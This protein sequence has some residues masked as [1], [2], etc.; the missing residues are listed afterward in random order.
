M[1]QRSVR[2]FRGG[3]IVLPF[4]LAFAG[5]CSSSSPDSSATA[6][7]GAERGACYPNGTCNTGLTCASN[8]CVVL[9]DAGT[10]DGSPIV[11]PGQDSS[12]PGTDAG[13]DA[14]SDGAV[15][16]TSG[17]M[18]V[19]ATI[20]DIDTGTV[21]PGGAVNLT[22]VFVTAVDSA[23]GTFWIADTLTAAESQGIVVVAPTPLPAGVVVG[24]KVDVGTA[25]VGSVKGL[26]QLGAIPSM[27][28]TP[29]VTVVMA[30]GN[31]PVGA[32]VTSA[33]VESAA[34]EAPWLGSLVVVSGP[35]K[36]T[37]VNG[38]GAAKRYTLTGGAGTIAMGVELY[39]PSTVV[40]TCYASV[41]SMATLD[42][43]P[44]T[45]VPMLLPRGLTDLTPGVGCP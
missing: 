37:A 4:A 24:A 44:A 6:A 15:P 39:D 1:Q 30:P 16:C 20:K 18:P 38:S 29:M 36:V 19:A 3:L 12:A 32:S 25:L 26:L 10:S 42:T 13:T 45:A 23:S 33:T 35:L 21:N 28:A 27:A 34:T 41:R 7:A 43:A 17:C 5:A 31:P 22:G 11:Q 2:A 8:V 40:G 14:G 9:A